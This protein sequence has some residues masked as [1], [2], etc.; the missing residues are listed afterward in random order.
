M[1]RCVLIG[2]LVIVWLLCLNGQVEA[3]HYVAIDGAINTEVDLPKLG[4]DS[5]YL[6]SHSLVVSDGGLP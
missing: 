1:K 5:A 2:L 3:Q 4:P 6:V